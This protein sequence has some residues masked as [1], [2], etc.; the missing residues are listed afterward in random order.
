M[1][2][3]SHMRRVFRTRAGLVGLG[4]ALARIGDAV[5][6]FYTSEWPSVLRPTAKGQHHHFVGNCYVDGMMDGEVST[7][8]GGDSDR[9]RLFHLQ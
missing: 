6:I 2:S 9:H 5:A 1:V 3:I 7:R 4:P 8:L